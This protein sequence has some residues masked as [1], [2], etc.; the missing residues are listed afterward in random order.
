SNNYRNTRILMEHR[1]VKDRLYSLWAGVG[2]A[3][4]SPKRLELLDMIAQGERTV[5]EL[6]RECGLS[7]NN[8]SSHLNV[9][10]AARLIEARKQS[11]SVYH[12]LAS[13]EVVHLLRSVQAVA[14]I[15]FHE[16]EHL[17]RT[18]LDGRDELEPLTASELRDRL[19]SGKVTLID[20]RP[21]IEYRAGHIKGA[22]SVPLERLDARL[23]DL[24]RG[25]P[26]VAYCRGP[27][28]LFAIDAVHRLRAKGYE[29]LRLSDGF[30][31]WA[32][33]GLP[34]ATGEEFITS[35]SQRSRTASSKPGRRVA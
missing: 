34:I 13:N 22:I 26:V 16:V 11:Q 21:E 29:S 7:I 23:R 27:Y 24:P 10:K 30:P 3:L 2:K 12:R 20:V 8:T 18:Y 4:A 35:S 1:Q 33:A 17:A 28:C 15:G 25:R 31:D 5:D 14:R 19:R 6:A 32:A 9:L